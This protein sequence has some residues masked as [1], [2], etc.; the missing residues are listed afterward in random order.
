V[1]NTTNRSIN[2]INAENLS[3]KARTTVSAMSG[4]CH[5]SLTLKITFRFLM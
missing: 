3:M 2:A 1:E 4:E 5:V